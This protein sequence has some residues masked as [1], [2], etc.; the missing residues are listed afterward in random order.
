MDTNTWDTE[1]EFFLNAFVAYPISGGTIKG[2]NR[3]I[4]SGSCGPTLGKYKS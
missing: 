2:N 4:I 3:C 1:G